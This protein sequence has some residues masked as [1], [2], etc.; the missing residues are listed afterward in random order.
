[1]EEK[2]LGT[3]VASSLTLWYGIG[4]D[5]TKSILSKM[6]KLK[7]EKRELFSRKSEQ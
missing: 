7:S 1:L 4:E 6:D 3:R 5:D 2:D